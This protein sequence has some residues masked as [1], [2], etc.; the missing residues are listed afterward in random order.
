MI[1]FE[2][3]SPTKIIFGK[4]TQKRVGT[5]VKKYADKVLLHYGGKSIKV[6]GLYDQI[7]RSLQEAGV[8]FIE[9]GGVQ[10]NPRLSLVYEG[11]V[12]CREHNI[13]FV[14]AVGGGSVI[15]SAKAIAMGV[16]HDGDVWDIYD[17]K[18]KVKAAL[19]VATVLT[20][21]AA[22]SE[23]SPNSVITNEQTLMKNGATSDA[24]RPVFSILNPE[25]CYTLPP[26]QMACGVSDILAHLMERYF[27]NTPHVDYSDR[28]LEGSM[29]SIIYSARRLQKVYSDY[30]SWANIMWGGLVAHNG[31]LGM[32]REEDW[33]SHTIE[34]QLSA[35][36]DIAHGAGLS[37]VFP[38]W[39]KYVN[40]V[41]K[42]RFLQFASRVMEVDCA[43]E[44]EDRIIALGI[45][46]LE[47]FYKKLGL[48]IRFMDIGKDDS[49]IKQMAQ[50]TTHYGPTG[51]FKKLTATDVEE[52]F[53]IALK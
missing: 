14:L 25:L 9:L 45:S 19:P 47:D 51:N 34:H 15:D 24:I 52:I 23:T 12:L 4:D 49:A 31:I 3:Y 46:R 5:Q 13:Q 20:I 8:S 41:N 29:K 10:P 37:I 2:Y 16:L 50:M 48:P 17:H 40:H 53:K 11:I 27:T 7:I 36:Y 43:F 44:D 22:G 30:D 32:G 18:A 42:K 6:S 21:P 26:Y 39:M 28:L 1:G 33:G 35:L 38:A